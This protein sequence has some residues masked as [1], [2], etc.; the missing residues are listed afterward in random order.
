[1]LHG[2]AAG[3]T[4]PSLVEM[5]NGV[6]RGRAP[7]SLLLTPK[8]RIVTEL[9]VARLANGDEGELLLHIPMSGVEEVLTHLAKFLPP[10][11]AKA[12]EPVNEVGSFFLVG[13]DAPEIVAREIF[14]S[15]LSADEVHFLLEG[16]ELSLPDPGSVGI[17]VV[18]S[19]TFLPFSV[20]VVA[21]SAT[22]S[23]IWTK[24]EGAGA[25]AAT[26]SGLQ[27]LLRLEKGRP[28]FGIEMDS[29]ILPPEAGV[30]D[31]SIDHRK[32][33]YTGQ[34]VIVRIRDRGHVNR[35]LRGI[36]LGD[37][38]PPEPGA[39]L[40]VAGKDDVVGEVRSATVSPRFGQTIALSYLRREVTPLA[41]IRLGGPEGPPGQVRGLTDS[42]WVLVEGDSEIP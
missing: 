27:D 42:G 34:E 2:M 14:D 13:P 17:R 29:D 22:L 40:Y 25:A 10:R 15:R 28:H 32:G 30:Q 6:E 39:L 3:E 1:M 26:D 31:R 41:E 12:V 24:L 11:F 18:R 35:Y 4:P 37:V 21:E 9:R 23:A 16:E 5:G 20:E 33:C 36:L 8:G 7:S 38:S 19:G